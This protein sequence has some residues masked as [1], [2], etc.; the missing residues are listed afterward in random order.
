MNKS[1]SK[2]RHIQEV[3]QKLENRL[4]TEKRKSLSSLNENNSNERIISHKIENL[5]EKPKVE[6][7]LESILANLSDEEKQSIMQLANMSPME[8]HNQVEDEME[9]ETTDQEM[10][11][12][13]QDNENKQR[14]LSKTLDNIAQANISAWGGVPLAIAIGG[15]I[16]TVAGGLAISWGAT[17]LLYGLAKLLSEKNS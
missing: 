17:A 8:I 4:L 16:G 10:E 3:N 5:V 6:Q 14:K 2:L 9:T 1:Y 7:K 15:A 12:G 13:E 11:M